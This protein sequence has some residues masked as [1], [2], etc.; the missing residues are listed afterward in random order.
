MGLK[1]IGALAS[2]GLWVSA[3]RVMNFDREPFG[4]TPPGW[5]ATA[6]SGA[7]GKWEI[8]KDSTAPTQPYVLAQVSDEAGSDRFPLAIWDGEQLRNA[9]ISVRIK[10]VSGRE[11][12]AGG[13]VFRYRNRENYYQV[14]ADARA[15][16]VA[17]YRVQDGRLIR[18][19]AAVQHDIP[20]NQW[21]ILKVALRGEQFQVYVDHRRILR[22]RDDTYTGP[23]KAGLFTVGDSV[24]YFDEFRLD[25]K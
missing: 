20:V 9:D 11:D 16:T 14:R 17:V 3:T 10:P 18:L 7:P 4:M 13:L 19:G 1:L 5:T 15:N 12:R 22:G 21:R 24:T 8:L 6:L 23:G 25:P 2:L